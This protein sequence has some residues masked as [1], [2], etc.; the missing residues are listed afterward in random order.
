MAEIREIARFWNEKSCGEVYA[1]GESLREQFLAQEQARYDLEPFI[2]GFAKFHEGAG[3]RVLEIGVGMG[4]DHIQWARSKPASLTGIDLT[5]R[6]V[7]FTKARLACEGLSSDVFTANAEELPMKDGSFDIVYSWGV[8]HHSARPD[9]AIQEVFRVLRPGG[10]ARIMIYHKYSIVAFLLWLGYGLR[11]GQ[12]LN[13][14]ISQ[15]LES[16]GTHAYSVSE[17]RKLF[18]AFSTLRIS[19][20]LSPGDLLAGEAGQRH[21]STALR[22]ARLIWPRSLIRLA[23]RLGLFMLID[24]HKG[25][26]Y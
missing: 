10:C 25:D 12:S 13:R 16:P 1:K 19:L 17:A 18:A 4:A 11:R 6:A 9:R 5:E 22:V 2:P 23:P 20:E 15:F 8:L 14:A 24:A 21:K 26:R 7:E 3:A